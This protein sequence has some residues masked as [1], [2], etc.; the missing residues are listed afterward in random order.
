MYNYTSQQNFSN[1][2]YVSN[3]MSTVS[4]R[5]RDQEGPVLGAGQ[6]TGWV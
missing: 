6:T 2:D 5:E 3:T 4:V 1:Q